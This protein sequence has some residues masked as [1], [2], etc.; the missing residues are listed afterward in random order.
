VN[1]GDDNDDVGG[2]GGVEQVI[3]RKAAV[4]YET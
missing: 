4:G 1:D 2:G 3:Y